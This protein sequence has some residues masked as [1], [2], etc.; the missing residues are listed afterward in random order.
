MTWFKPQKCGLNVTKLVCVT[1]SPSPQ[2]NDA[3]KAKNDPLK[4]AKT[5]LTPVLPVLH[6]WAATG[7]V[8]ISSNQ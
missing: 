7:A 8:F 5:E 1:L 4:Y 6:P 2:Q 3:L